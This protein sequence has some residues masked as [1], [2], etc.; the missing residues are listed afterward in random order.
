[1]ASTYR[2]RIIKSSWGVAVDL[3]AEVGSDATNAH[4]AADNVFLRIEAPLKLNAEEHAG[5]I[6]GLRLVAPDIGAC[7]A[8]GSDTV[9]RLLALEY[10]FC[11][12]Q[13]EGLVC[14]IANWAA[15]EYG[16]APPAIRV[17][18]DRVA[19]R[20]AFDFILNAQG[21]AE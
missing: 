3:T 13:P 19:R 20:Y 6:Q 17:T 10:N 7:I 9:V 4:A 12:Y 2:Y 15:Q 8:P 11:D 14:A 18:F 5:I 16:F 1:M 21:E